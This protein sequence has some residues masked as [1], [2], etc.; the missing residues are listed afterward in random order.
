MRR[1]KQ[2]TPVQ[3]LESFV[4]NLYAR[5]PEHRQ[6]IDACLKSYRL[7]D[8]RLQ[9]DD[10]LMLDL[11]ELSKKEKWAVKKAAAT[12]AKKS[13]VAASRMFG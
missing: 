3:G 9:N 1:R 8:G 2:L 12:K 11:R 7:P 5:Y 6:A 10:A 4:E 13:G